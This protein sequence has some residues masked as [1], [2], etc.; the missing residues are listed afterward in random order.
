LEWWEG[1]Q[2]KQ[3]ANG[4][5]DRSATLMTIATCLAEADAV[6]EQIAEALAERDRTLG[7]EKYTNRKDFREYWRMAQKAIQFRESNGASDLLDL[8]DLLERPVSTTD[9]DGKEATEE[10]EVPGKSLFLTAKQAVEQV[11]D[12]A[13]GIAPPWV[14]KGAVTE[15][16]GKI[17]NAGKTTFMLAMVKKW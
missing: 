8:Q 6:E 5:I 9:G 14:H 1:G 4:T 11:P 13:I 12:K 16:D 2:V 3:G 15:L 7:Y 17:K 10:Q